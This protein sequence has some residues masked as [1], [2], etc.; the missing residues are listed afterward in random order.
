MT[1]TILVT[2]ATGT[3]GRTLVPLLL[4]GGH[5]VRALVHDPVRAAGVLGPDVELS[6][7]RAR[8]LRAAC[9]G[10]DAVYVA[11]GNVPDQVR[12]ESAVLDAAA[13]AGVDRIVKLSARGADRSAEVAYWRWHA[14]LEQRLAATGVPATVL[15]PGFYMTNLLALA[16]GLRTAGR[17]FAP[18]GNAAVA[19]IDPGDVAAAAAAALTTE[20]L[21]GTWEL[22]G[23]RALTFQDVAAQL[24]AG[25]GR[26]LGYVDVPGEV[27]RAGLLAT[28]APPFAAEQVLSVFAALRRGEQAT[29]T[30]AVRVLTDRPARSLTGFAREHAAAFGSVAATISP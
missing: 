6:T 30:D 26:R 4:S 7:L 24:G 12:R 1:T 3:V 23:P 28:G 16:E 29:T 19:M 10:V 2:G 22:T 17:L 15:R 13:R 8:P 25:L 5:H 11:C 27:A 18:A 9:A 14:E 20:G 21:D